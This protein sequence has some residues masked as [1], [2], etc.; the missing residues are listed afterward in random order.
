[1][2]NKINIIFGA[3]ASGKT[4]YGV[5]L[6]KQLDGEVIN[7]DSMQVYHEIPIISAAPTENEKQDIPHH[8]YGFRSAFN[9]YSAGEFITDATSKILEVQTR[10]KTPILVGGTGLYIKTLVEGLPNLPNIS[11]HI[12]AKVAELSKAMSPEEMHTYLNNL[13]PI[14]AA[15]LKPND[16]QRIMRALAVIIECGR[17]LAELQ[18]LPKVALFPRTDYHIIWLNPDRKLVYE[19][20][21]QRL[22][23]MIELGAIAEVKS[24]L[25]TSKGQQLPKA[26]GIPEIQQYL[27]GEI[28]LE[29]AIAKAQ[30]S[31]RNY[32]K[33]QITWARHQFEFDEII[34]P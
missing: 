5:K 18:S 27:R 3:T 9:P 30:Q 21:N 14:M 24:L 25:A 20:I 6:A 10:S 15:K 11:K 13:D 4:A 31:T 29:E 28:T 12:K 23:C 1:V 34:I 8:L 17:S 19:K 33:R 16:K 26:C 22:M 2:H 7:A 32:A